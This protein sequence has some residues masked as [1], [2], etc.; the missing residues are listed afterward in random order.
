MIAGI[1]ILLLAPVWWMG[2]C[3]TV[4]RM[5]RLLA[6]GG[7]WPAAIASILGI[8]AMHEFGVQAALSNV[9]RNAIGE[10]LHTAVPIKIFHVRYDSW[11]AR[12]DSLR[13]RSRDIPIHVSMLFQWHLIERSGDGRIYLY[14][15]PVT[16]ASI[17]VLGCN[18]SQEPSG[19][20]VWNY[21]L[22]TGGVGYFDRGAY[23]EAARII[24]WPG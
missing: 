23:G 1:K 6:Y 19:D 22:S 10:H 9:L 7:G 5:A 4:R 13:G 16:P 12:D 3:C 8:F 2:F 24:P 18:D 15:L 21:D 20:T 14:A 11:I 17:F